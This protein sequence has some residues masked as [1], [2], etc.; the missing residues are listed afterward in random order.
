[1]IQ[2]NDVRWCDDCHG[3]K[4]TFVPVKVKIRQ[5]GGFGWELELV[6]PGLG[7]N[8][9]LHPKRGKKKTYY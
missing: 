2:E 1:M 3:G 8:L 9:T 5:L 6:S 4:L 7:R